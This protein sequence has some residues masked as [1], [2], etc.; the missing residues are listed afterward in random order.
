MSLIRSPIAYDA[1]AVLLL[2]HAR[3]LL[4]SAELEALL[5]RDPNVLSPSLSVKESIKQHLADGLIRDGTGDDGVARFKLTMAGLRVLE[6]CTWIVIRKRVPEAR[7]FELSTR[8]VFHTYV[9]AARYAEQN[10]GWVVQGRFLE[11]CPYEAQG[12]WPG[13]P[14]PAHDLDG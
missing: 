2:I 14:L 4:S 13:E 1:H 9:A 10:E 11:L 3:Q 7:D 12:G 5:A 8:T 6:R